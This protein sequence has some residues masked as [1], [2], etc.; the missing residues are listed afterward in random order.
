M[1]LLADLT[2]SVEAASVIGIMGMMLIGVIT[3][4]FFMLIAQFEDRIKNKEL[5]DQRDSY[6]EIGAEAVAH[7]RTVALKKLE[8][9]GKVPPAAIADVVPEHSSPTTQKQADVAELQTMRAQLVASTLA[10]DLPPRE[11]S[12]MKGSEPP[13]AVDEPSNKE[14][15]KK[16]DEIQE[17]QEKAKT[18]PKLVTIVPAKDPLPVKPVD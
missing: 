11:A 12:P 14:V 1:V 15:M 6:K 7:L 3:K 13:P 17:E 9:E 18:E 4:L 16:L 10:L 2:I 5:S 8:D